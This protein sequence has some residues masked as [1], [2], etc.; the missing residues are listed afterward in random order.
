MIRVDVPYESIKI[1]QGAR[2]VMVGA[3][4]TAV[5]L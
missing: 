4:G 3:S 1:G 2:T 5:R